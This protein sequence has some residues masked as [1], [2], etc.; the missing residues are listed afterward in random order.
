VIDTGANVIIGKANEV[1]LKI[2]AEPH[3]QYELRD[4]FTFEVEGAKF[5]PHTVREIGM[6]RYTY[7][8]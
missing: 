2:N 1:F 4:H 3:I 6:E 8:I 5:M 7:S